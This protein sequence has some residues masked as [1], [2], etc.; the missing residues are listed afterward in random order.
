VPIYEYTCRSCAHQFEALVRAS[1]TPACP[2]CAS[3]DLERRF[4]MPAVRSEATRQVVSRDVKQRDARQ[5]AERVHAQREY[6]RNH[7]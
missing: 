4:S 5:A 3:E 6:E 2:E 7:D 1:S